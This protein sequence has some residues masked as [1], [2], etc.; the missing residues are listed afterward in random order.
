M[1]AN[2]KFACKQYNKLTKEWTVVSTHGSYEMA[3]DACRFNTLIATR[4][5]HCELEYYPRD[6]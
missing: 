5:G 3:Q 2:D 1:D 4:T 6:I